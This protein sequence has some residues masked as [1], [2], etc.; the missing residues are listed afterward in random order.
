MKSPRENITKIY[1]K[2]KK[3]IH[4]RV[5]FY[6]QYLHL[7]IYF[8]NKVLWTKRIQILIKITLAP[9]VYLTHFYVCSCHKED[10]NIFCLPSV[11]QSTTF[12][13][14]WGLKLPSVESCTQ[15]ECISNCLLPSVTHLWVLVAQSC[16]TLCYPMDCSLPPG[17]SVHEILQARVWKWV[18]ISFSRGYSWPRDSTLVSCIAGGSFTI[19]ATRESFISQIVH[20]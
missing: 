20:I 19:R 1:L 18:A 14:E 8:D 7:N 13:V 5:K 16:L 2:W 10:P 17:S 9:S 4:R 12:T 11:F 3:K 15:C 6:S